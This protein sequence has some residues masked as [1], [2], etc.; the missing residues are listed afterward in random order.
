MEL[1][2]LILNCWLKLKYTHQVHYTPSEKFVYKNNHH[3]QKIWPWNMAA[4]SYIENQ[5]FSAK[6]NWFFASQ[7][8][9]FLIWV[10]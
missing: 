1:L 3:H 4:T 9:F 10:N 2:Y 5:F 7:Q 8:I 6:A